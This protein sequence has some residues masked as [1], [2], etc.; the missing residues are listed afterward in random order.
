MDPCSGRAI[1][2]TKLFENSYY[3]NGYNL[4]EASFA[5]TLEHRRMRNFISVK[6]VSFDKDDICIEMECG[7]FSLHSYIK[8]TRFV[9]RIAALPSI[10]KC[11]VTGLYDLHQ[12]SLVR[13]LSVNNRSP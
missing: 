3:L 4:N 13:S 9:E 11:L 7:A 6:D 12:N 1:K 2:R 5:R 10:L 8:D